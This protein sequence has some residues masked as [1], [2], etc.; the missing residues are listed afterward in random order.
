MEQIKIGT[1]IPGTLAEDWAPH[2][3]KA[4]FETVSINFHMSLEGI[5]LKELAPKVKGILGDKATVGA[6]GY[7]CNA[8][9]YEDHRETLKKC[10]DSAP[11]FGTSIVST[12]A[13][14]IENESV[15]FA[16]P[17]FKEV[18]SEL[19]KYAEDRGVKIAIENCPMGGTWQRATCNIGFNPKAWEMMFNEVDSDALG[20]EWEPAHQMVQLIDPIINLREWVKKVIHLHGK[21]ATID[22]DAVKRYGVY[23]NK[24]FS[25]SRTPGFGDTNWRDI[26][27][28]LYQ[29]GFEGD[30]CVEGYHDPIYSGD[31]EMTSQ[32]H[33][34]NYLKWARG[35][36]FTAN[37]WA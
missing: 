30:V 31:W 13:G 1:C 20:L 23:G 33:A 3:V 12:F 22:W 6:L 2:M 32:L 16:M 10:I 27:F 35:G 34:L 26:F 7:Y 5:D 37:P 4:G 8:L 18:F 17:K 29:N 25:Y 19:T 11:L 21:D 28:I 36:K 15:D 14:A 9:Q 24:E